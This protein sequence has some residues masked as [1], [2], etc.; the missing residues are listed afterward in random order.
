MWLSCARPQAATGGLPAEGRS[1]PSRSSSPEGS[2]ASSRC[3]GRA[4]RSTGRA[5]PTTTAT[6]SP[7]SSRASSARPSGSRVA[8]RRSPASRD[9]Q[10]RISEEVTLPMEGMAQPGV[11][12]APLAACP[13]RSGDQRAPPRRAGGSPSAGAT[14][15]WRSST[16]FA[17]GA[18]PSSGA[19]RAGH[20]P[21]QAAEAPHRRRRAFPGVRL[22]DPSRA[23]SSPT[24]SATPS[25]G[26]SAASSAPPS[27][28]TARSTT[29][30]CACS[31][32]HPRPTSA[33]RSIG[34][35]CPTE[36][37]VPSDATPS[38]RTAS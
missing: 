15:R 25:S 36:A 21:R 24:R 20:H 16:S 19:P 17:D 31:R 7:T 28:W 30:L 32:A 4:T 27:S 10:T 9:V 6:A 3:A 18:R 35:F 26:W 1:R 37:T 29:S 13:R 23:R 12:A 34:S 11:R 14:T 2:C 38:S 5:R 22:R 33:R 8:S